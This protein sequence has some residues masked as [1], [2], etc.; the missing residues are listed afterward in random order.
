MTKE[1]LKTKILDEYKNGNIVFSNIEG[2]SVVNLEDF[3]TQ[4]TEGMLYDLNR[5]PE[6]VCTFLDDPKWVNDY[7]VAVVIAKLKEKIATQGS[8]QNSQT[9]N[10]ST[11]CKHE[12]ATPVYSHGTVFKCKLCG[13]L[14]E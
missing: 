2:L 6:V 5:L 4:P 8:G 1:E 13:E 12:N 9:T 11:P 3:I 7:A 14:F 10:A